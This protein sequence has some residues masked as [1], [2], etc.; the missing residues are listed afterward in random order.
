MNFATDPEGFRS[1]HRQT[2]QTGHAEPEDRA[3]NR[4]APTNDANLLRL[5]GPHASRHPP[6][7]EDR[8]IRE[9]R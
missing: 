4:Q 2:T 7:D 8:S 3:Q 5:S 1:S 6:L 9:A